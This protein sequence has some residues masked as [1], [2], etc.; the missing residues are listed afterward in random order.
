M[1]V[2]VYIDGINSWIDRW[3][4][5]QKEGGKKRRSGTKNKEMEG[6]MD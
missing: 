1:S 2:Y 3:T 5:R 4:E 6:W